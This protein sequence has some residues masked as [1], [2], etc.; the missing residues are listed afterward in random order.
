[1]NYNKTDFEAERIYAF[2]YK[3]LFWL[4]KEHVRSQIWVESK[5]LLKNQFL[6]FRD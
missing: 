5:E 3:Y 6:R 2:L 1:M 4:T